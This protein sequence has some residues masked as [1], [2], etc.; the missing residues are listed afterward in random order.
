MRIT[1]F[2]GGVTAPI[3]ASVW[4]DGT[5]AVVPR[6]DKGQPDF[7]KSVVIGVVHGFAASDA[8]APKGAS[9]TTVKPVVKRKG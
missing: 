2:G 5:V 3:T 8:P 4:K 9:K 1:I 6:D 7:T